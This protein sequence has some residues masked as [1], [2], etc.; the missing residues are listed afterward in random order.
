MFRKFLDSG[1]G[2]TEDNISACGEL[3]KCCQIEKKDSDALAAMF[4]SF[5]FDLPRAELCCQIGYF[6]KLRGQWR[7]A[8]FWFNLALNVEKPQNS[9]GF[10]QKDC[11]GYIPAIECAV[12]YDKLGNHETAEQYNN[13]AAEFK[14]YA[15]EV[16]Y[17]KKYFKGLRQ[18]AN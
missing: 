11:W 16:L 14:P 2:W 18:A 7:Q 5:Q 4:R 3:A 10:L 8:A 17:N 6:F 12:C 13:K 9:W 1:K 15:P